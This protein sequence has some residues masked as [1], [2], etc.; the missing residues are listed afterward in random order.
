MRPREFHDLPRLGGAVVVPLLC[1]PAANAQGPS[2][3]LRV[4]VVS[5]FSPRTAVPFVAL[6]HFSLDSETILEP[7]S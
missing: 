6:E 5:S 3:L 4:G 1:P 2:R 7:C